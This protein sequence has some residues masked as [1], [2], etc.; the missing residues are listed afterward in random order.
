MN[1]KLNKIAYIDE[2][3]KIKG[4]FSSMFALEFICKH[5]NIKPLGLVSI[6]FFDNT[7]QAIDED[8]S[9]EICV[10][11][12]EDAQGDMI[13]KIYIDKGTNILLIGTFTNQ[14]TFTGMYINNTE[15][16]KPTSNILNDIALK[17]Y[18]NIN[19]YIATKE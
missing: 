14:L 3:N 6:Q 7:L 2:E 8:T 10:A 9:Y 19:K 17:V 15:I 5:M 4:P 16:N 12:C 11:I 13:L 1:Y 18:N